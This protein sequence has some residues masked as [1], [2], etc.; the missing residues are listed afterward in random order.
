MKRKI[1]DSIATTVFTVALVLFMLTVCIGLP[2][3]CRFFYYLQIGPLGLEKSTGY[4]YETIKT[5]YDQVLDYLT[6][7][8]RGFAAGALKFSE[9]GAAHFADCKFLFNLNLGIMLGSLAVL[10]WT[11]VFAKLKK[12]RLMRP[13]GHSSSVVAAIIAVIL[14]VA[15]GAAAAADFGRAFEIF[16]SIF[17]PGKTNWVFD[18]KKDEIIK[19][20]PEQ[21]FIN[22]AIFIG[23]GL[24][25]FAAGIFVFDAVSRR[26]MK[27]RA[28]AAADYRPPKHRMV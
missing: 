18:P 23:A 25:V 28:Q 16:H 13:F 19:I 12:I 7:P 4:S 21:F 9:D 1:I 22:C 27:K 20:L 17:F 3:Y 8:G 6:L 24:I 11:G 5:A 26:R 14:P 10:I 2:I 15:T